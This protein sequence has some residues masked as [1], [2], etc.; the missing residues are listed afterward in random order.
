VTNCRN[1]NAWCRKKV[2]GRFLNVSQE[3]AALP[4]CASQKFLARTTTRLQGRCA[5][6]TSARSIN[7]GRTFV[8]TCVFAA[9]VWTLALSVSPQLHQRVHADASRAEHSCAV[10]AIVSGAYEHAGSPLL[11]SGS[12]PAVQFS[13]IAALTSQ[14]VESLFL[15]AHIF[16]NAPPTRG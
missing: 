15:K 2:A 5:M 4:K 13:K 11:V 8:A 6:S 16:A 10:T 9:F 7:H 12:L 3:T 14:G 1:G